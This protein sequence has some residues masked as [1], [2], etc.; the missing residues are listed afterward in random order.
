MDLSSLIITICL[1]VQSVFP[2]P[3]Q[4][5]GKTEIRITAQAVPLSFSFSLSALIGSRR[6]AQPSTETPFSF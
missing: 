1:L 4:P 5:E 3:H 2:R 6:I